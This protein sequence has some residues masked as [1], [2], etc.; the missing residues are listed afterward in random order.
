M[1]NFDSISFHLGERS[2][3]FD[4][5]SDDSSGV[6]ARFS[7]GLLTPPPTPSSQGN[8]SERNISSWS[9]N[10]VDSIRVQFVEGALRL[11]PSPVNDEEDPASSLSESSMAAYEGVKS[12]FETQSSQP[13]PEPD[14]PSNEEVGSQSSSEGIADALSMEAEDPQ[15]RLNYW[16][17]QAERSRLAINKKISEGMLFAAHEYYKEAVNAYIRAS[18]TGANSALPYHGLAEMEF[19]YGNYKTAAEYDLK[20][21]ELDSGHTMPYIRLAKLAKAER[22]FELAKEYLLKVLALDPLHEG[23]LNGIEE[24]ET[25]QKLL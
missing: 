23:A 6:S 2:D 25:I 9:T 18:Q 17:V 24:I 22:K 21:I 14:S 4:A 5:K 16:I 7:D 12:L 1:A 10:E 19:E 15:T 13:S 11:V 3:S 8:L 20:A